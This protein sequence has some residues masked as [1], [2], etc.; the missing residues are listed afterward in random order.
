MLLDD[1]IVNIATVASSRYAG[2]IK[3]RVDKLQKQL[4]LF[5]QTLVIRVVIIKN[6][7]LCFVLFCFRLIKHSLSLFYCVSRMSGWYVREAGFILRV[8]SVLLTSRGSCL[9]SLSRSCKWTSP[10]KRL[11]G[12]STACPMPFVLPHRVR[13]RKH[14]LSIGNLISTTQTLD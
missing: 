11:W 4:L 3:A 10:G 8:F 13:L 1:S 9:L 7:V 14:T 5:S 2:S 12:R 6:I